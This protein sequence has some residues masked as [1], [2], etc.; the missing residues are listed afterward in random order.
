VVFF[1]GSPQEKE[2]AM[3]DAS[4]VKEHME[5]K[6]ADG[7]HVG[8]VDKVEGSRIKLTK[9][10]PASGGAHRY[11]DLSSVDS[12]EGGAINL[13]KSDDEVRRTWQ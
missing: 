13:S 7:R 2:Q 5:V 8:V 10:D 4:H 3:I 11:I 6:G 9:S 1:V 12:I